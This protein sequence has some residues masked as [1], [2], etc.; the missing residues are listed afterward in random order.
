MCGI[1][2]IVGAR[3]VAQPEIWRMCDAIRHRGPDDWGTFIE[4]GFG[5]GMRRL[6]IIDLAGGH[7]PMGNEDDNLQVVLNGESAPRLGSAASSALISD[8]NE[9]RPSRTV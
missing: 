2:G 9:S 3:E 6:S 1:V 5:M 8:A 4:G 7:Q